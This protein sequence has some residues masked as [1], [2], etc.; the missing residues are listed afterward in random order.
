MEEVQP[1]YSAL[2]L[3]SLSLSSFKASSWFISPCDTNPFSIDVE[4][5]NWTFNYSNIIEI[6]SDGLLS[7]SKYFLF[8]SPT[9]NPVTS[10]SGQ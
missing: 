7:L 9:S 10:S 3:T 6:E 8:F 4:I 2:S 5:D 1:V